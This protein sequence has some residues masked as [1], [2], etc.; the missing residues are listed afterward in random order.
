MTKWQNG[1]VLLCMAGI[2]AACGGG[3]G[4]TGD[5]VSG[6]SHDVNASA[7]R[8]NVVVILVDDLGYSDLSAFG[9]EIRTPNID[10]LAAEGQILTNF[11]ATPLCATS[12]AAL[13]TGADH[14]LVGMGTLPES[15]L[16]YLPN[17]PN[18]EGEL[19]S[20]GLT[21]AQL[22][23]DAGYHTY[24]SG[25]WHL[26][27]TGPQSKGFE[28]SFS[29]KYDAAFASNFAPAANS[30]KAPGF[31]PYYENGKRVKNKDLTAD[32][33]SS[34]AFTTKLIDQIKGDHGDG[35]PFFAYLSYQAMHFPLQAPDKYLDLYKGAY[36]TGYAVIREAR[37]KRM[38]DLGIIPQDFQANPG[39]E[40]VMARFGQ[41]GP[42]LNT[43]WSEL[44]PEQ[45]KSEARIMEVYAAMLAN[46]DDNIGR[47]VAY[48]KSIGEY[49]NTLIVFL[50]D[51]GA[52]G[53]GYGFVPYIDDDEINTDMNNSLANY[54][55]PGSFL[56]RSTRWAE[57]GS[58]P[59]RLYKGYTAEGGI[60]VPA[61]V[62]MP[63]NQALPQ[64]AAYANLRDIA[65]TVL[66]LA[67]VS[68]PGDT[69]NGQSV[70]AIEGTSL[71]PILEGRAASVHGPD[72]VFAGEVN[73]IRYVLKGPWKLTRITNYLIPVGAALLPHQWQ[74]YNMDTDRG[75][76]HDVA[77][78]YPE[79]TQELIREWD[80]YVQRVGV[81]TPFLPPL[82]PPVLPLDLES[83]LGPV[84]SSLKQ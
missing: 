77:A 27:G 71:L 52:D 57:V 24:M 47:L 49:D 55:K 80:K 1:L 36:D 73:D 45:R 8:A 70:A 15:N 43:A 10:E 34:D 69:Y 41:P 53:Y 32:F 59:F 29:L 18:Y 62:K 54:G 19:N 14:H 75:E 68:S 79:K 46:M 23:Q 7:Q 72:E 21:I 33:F 44:L 17:T 74:L 60:A 22:L 2:L 76:N 56:F 37:I 30:G 58:A 25:K 4:S 6:A 50:S 12:R 20:R 84:L 65:P 3:S 83:I 51:N 81:A 63:Q 61:I 26:G 48:L 11:H 40:A 28:Q 42:L 16:A 67:K 66:S 35:Q 13:L 39:D 82:L 9:S 78:Q 38:K 64:S 31:Q 5:E